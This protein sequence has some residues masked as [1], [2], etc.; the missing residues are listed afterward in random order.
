MRNPSGS[1]ATSDHRGTSWHGVRSWG[2]CLLACAEVAPCSVSC[3]T[4]CSFTGPPLL[5]VSQCHHLSPTS[6]TVKS[7]STAVFLKLREREWDET[8][9]DSF[10]QA[11][12]RSLLHTVFFMLLAWS[13]CGSSLFSAHFRFWLYMCDMHMY[14]FSF[15][16]HIVPR[17]LSLS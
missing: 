16:S 12:P 7:K 9:R 17:G 3:S 6:S 8:G 13:S 2:I 11:P 4:D 5:P 14:F 10:L 15:L 1:A